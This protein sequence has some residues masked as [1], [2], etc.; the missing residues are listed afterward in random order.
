M[1]PGMQRK[2]QMDMFGA[3]SLTGFSL[4]LAFNQIVIKFVNQGLQPVFFAGLRSVIAIFCL[5]LWMRVMGRP[6]RLRRRYAAAGV[7]AGVAFAVEF[8]CLF[9]AL[10]LTTVTRTS[11]I[12]Y[13]MP[14]WLTLAA[15]FILPDERVTGPKALGL[16]L[17]FAGVAL[18]M[19][20]RPSGPGQ[21][22]LLGDL[23]A[24][25]AAWGWAGIALVVRGTNLR[26]ER[27]EMQ[28]FWQVLVSAVLLVGVAPFFGPLIRDFQ[29]I[30]IAGLAFQ[31]VLVVTA[32]YM[33]WLW[34]L[35]VYPAGSVASFSFLTPVFGVFMGWLVLEEHVGLPILVAA[36]LVAVGI[37]LINR[38]VRA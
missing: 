21:A 35:T 1:G 24:L 13:S 10:D 23:F 12:L 32:G 19:L 6:V 4:F 26:E 25:M 11:I 33:F 16:V 15:H 38:P 22:S 34:L 28:L 31:G 30:H 36:A 37:I 29:P 17:A 8:I 7:L 5:M 20:A 2:R 9:L 18:A 3:V 27:P 14:V